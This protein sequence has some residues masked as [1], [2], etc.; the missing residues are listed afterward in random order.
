MLIIFKEYLNDSSSLQCFCDVGIQ[1]LVKISLLML[2]HVLYVSFLLT[3]SLIPVGVF[4]LL[5]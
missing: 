1:Q 2:F 5:G 4:R 3:I